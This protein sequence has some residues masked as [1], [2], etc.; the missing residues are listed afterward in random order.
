MDINEYVDIQMVDYRD[1][2]KSSYINGCVF[3]K[4]LAGKK[5]PKTK[6]KPKILL[7][8]GSLGFMKEFSDHP[9][10]APD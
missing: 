6:D 5:M 10:K 8:K 1:E 2:T 4:N 9:D 3:M 7:L